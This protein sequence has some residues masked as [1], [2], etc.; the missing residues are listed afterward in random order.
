MSLETTT[1]STIGAAPTSRLAIVEALKTVPGLSVHHTAPDNP[2]AWD[3]FPRWA[4]TN[5][6]G[7]RLQWLGVHEYDALVILPAGYEPDTVEQ[8]DALL[9]HVAA[10]LLTV[11]EVR[12]AD[13]IQLTFNAGTAMPALRVRVVP[14]LNAHLGGTSHGRR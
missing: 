5:Y 9:D 7:G 3:A 1:T 12:A 10:A 11:G 6:T 2:H 13:P 14:H 8:G 4:I